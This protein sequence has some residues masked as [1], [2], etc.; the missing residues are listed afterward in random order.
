MLKS[1]KLML[2]IIED[3]KDELI[4]ELIRVTEEEVKEYCNFTNDAQLEKLN[5]AIKNMVILK[6]NRLGAEGLTAENYSGNSFSYMSDY[7]ESIIAVLNRNRR[8]LI[9]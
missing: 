8:A 3:D 2:G 1:I 9:L 4:N 6:Y 5:G 7:P